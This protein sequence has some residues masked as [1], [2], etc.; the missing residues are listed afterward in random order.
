VRQ[1]RVMDVRIFKPEPMGLRDDMLRLPFDAR[2]N[3]DGQHTILF[4]NFENL[5]VKMIDVVNAARDRI[6]AIVEP[7]GHK[8]YSVVNYDGFVLD[9]DVED[10]YLDA[11]QEMG[12]RYFHGVTRFTTSAFMHAKLGDALA[13]RGAAYLRIGGGG[14]GRRT[15]DDAARMIDRNRGEAARI[16]CSKALPKK[17]W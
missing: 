10:A 5:E 2:F 4:L 17:V 8:V 3:Y 14:K 9:R 6:R 15:R 16:V 13:T 1:P 11:V 7:L 12:E